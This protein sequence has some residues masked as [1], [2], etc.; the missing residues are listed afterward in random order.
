LDQSVETAE[1]NQLNQLNITTIGK[2]S[3]ESNVINS[4]NELKQTTTNLQKP[5]DQQN[6]SK[7]LDLDITK[8]ETVLLKNLQNNLNNSKQLLDDEEKMKM[9][10]H[11]TQT[12]RVIA[13]LPPPLPQFFIPPPPPDLSGLTNEKKKSFLI[14]N[15]DLVKPKNMTI[16]L[17][18]SNR[19]KSNIND[20]QIE[21]SSKIGFDLNE[22]KNFKFKASKSNSKLKDHVNGSNQNLKR[23]HINPW[24]NLMNEIKK[25]PCSKLKKVEKLNSNNK[26][27]IYSVST[28]NFNFGNDSSNLLRDLNLILSQRKIFFNDNEYEYDSCDVSQIWY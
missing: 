25:N 20:L 13:P 2:I 11:T 4:K 16:E 23:Q 1:I 18:N 26:Q 10:V 15:K 6:V 21:K 12:D 5:E 19:K 7:D 3:V 27:R 14:C 9:E 17:T 22:I 8:N 28:E 24:D